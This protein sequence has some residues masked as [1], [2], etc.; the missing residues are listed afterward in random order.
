MRPVRL[1][2]E[3]TH[4][5]WTRTCSALMAVCTAFSYDMLGSAFTFFSRKV[6]A[7]VSL[8]PTLVACCIAGG[9]QVD[10][11]GT[12]STVQERANRY[13]LYSVWFR[14]IGPQPSSQPAFVQSLPPHLCGHRPSATTQAP[15]SCSLTLYPTK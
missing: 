4:T 9:R 1:L 8:P 6:V 12:S 2:L 11:V 10:A 15:P 7:S 13:L 14:D 5:A 3:S